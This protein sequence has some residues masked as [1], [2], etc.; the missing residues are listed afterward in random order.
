[1]KLN[2]PGLGWV[3]DGMKNEKEETS[4]SIGGALKSFI[5]IG[6]RGVYFIG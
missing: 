2:E 3:E 1:M 4:M 6:G 5:G